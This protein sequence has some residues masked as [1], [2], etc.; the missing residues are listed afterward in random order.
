MEN[1]LKKENNDDINNNK[2]MNKKKI[3]LE[4]LNS[5][6]QGD[7]IGYLVNEENEKSNIDLEI[8]LKK[9]VDYADIEELAKILNDEEI[10]NYSNMTQIKINNNIEKTKNESTQSTLDSY[11][12]LENDNLDINESKIQKRKERKKPQPTL[13]KVLY[14][15]DN[16]IY[17]Y[18]FIS[19]KICNSI[20]L[21]CQD[22]NCKS[23]ATYNY[24]TKE[25]NIY[26]NHSIPI[27]KHIYLTDKSTDTIKELVS[28]MN[29]N[30]QIKNV[31][32]YNDSSKKIIDNIN[33]IKN[34]EKTNSDLNEINDSSMLFLNKKRHNSIKFF[35]EKFK[36]KKIVLFKSIKKKNKI[37]IRKNNS[38]KFLVK[39]IDKLDNINQNEVNNNEKI[40]NIDEKEE[41]IENNIKFHINNINKNEVFIIVKDKYLK[42]KQ[43]LTEIEQKIIGENKRFGTHFHKNEKDEVYNF[44]GNNKEIKDFNMNYRCTLKGCKSSAIYNLNLREFKILRE[45]TKP[46]EEHFCFKPN[47]IKT[48]QIVEYLRNNKNITDLQ[49]ILI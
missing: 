13:S 46:Y 4:L 17:I 49:I 45:H 43:L 38:K 42:H 6:S 16:N 8:K 40:I 5:Y 28:Y 47:K 20:F 34:S 26:E 30:P 22:N 3:V 24:L 21:R 18:R 48:K 12:K 31:E 33:Q 36:D 23:K 37:K 41:K 15:K 2:Y 39:S 29:L 10:I 44:F 9:L 19:R 25:L 27:E 7:I 1:I 32:V 14:R 35:I 11:L